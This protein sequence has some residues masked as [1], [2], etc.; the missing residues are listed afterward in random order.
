M[1]AS[2]L[3]EIRNAR[4]VFE[5]RHLFGR[6][7]QVRAVDDVSLVLHAGETLGL[8]GET[9]SGKSTLGRLVTRLVEPTFGE[10]HFDGRNL[11]SLSKR[12]L[13][14]ARHDI[15]MVF[16]DPY[17]SLDPRM[18]IRQLLVE[19][20]VV[21]G[22][23]VAGVAPKLAALMERVGLS[24]AQLDRYPHQFSGGQR[25][26]IGIA[27]AIILNPR[28]LILDEPVSA[29]DVSVQAQILNLVS[30]LQRE[31]GLAM[32]FIAHD[33]A[34]VRHV[35]HRIAVL[36]LGRVVETGGRD[37]IFD[38]PQH[39]YTN[40]LLSA[41]P[42][43]DPAAARARKTVMPIG[44]IGSAMDIPSGCRFHPRCPKAR[45]AGA[46]NGVVT[47]QLGRDAIAAVCATV[48]PQLQAADGMHQVACH[49]PE[50]PLVF[51]PNTWSN[52]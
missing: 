31:R 20:L 19:P 29:L 23:S 28:L 44:E 27:R 21:H 49:F 47:R 15:Q 18:T 7:S 46:A 8:V 50:Q 38:R 5:T 36:Y 16:Q 22:E 9:G 52:Q 51:Q 13:R 30:G 37:D 2:P 42:I 26:R 41:V 25:Q 39:P 48:E 17:G 3:L 43:P 4:K 33:L 35:S 40:S 11:V 10:I 34:V 45:Q 24:A 6:R 32:L 1:Q 12:E 14:S